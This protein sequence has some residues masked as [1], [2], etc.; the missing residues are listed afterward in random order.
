MKSLCAA[1]LLLASGS[2]GFAQNQNTWDGFVTD[3]HCGTNCQRTSA[4]TPDSACVRRC[5][6]GGSKYGLW[7]ENHI[8]VL[9]PQ[10]QAA[11]FAAEKVRVSGDLSND[12]IQIKSI[13]RLPQQTARAHPGQ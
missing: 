6:K 12:T 2:L 8:Y 5:V 1:M 7:C 3:T 9:E 10:S 11:K 4:M 13:V